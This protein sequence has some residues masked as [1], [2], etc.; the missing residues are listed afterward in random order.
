MATK[1]KEPKA[2]EEQEKVVAPE[3]AVSGPKWIKVTAEQLAKLQ[4]EGKLVG[5]NPDTNEALIK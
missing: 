5:Y 1:R 2:A 3:V 4:V